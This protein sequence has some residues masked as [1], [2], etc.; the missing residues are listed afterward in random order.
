LRRTRPFL[1]EADSD[2]ALRLAAISA[3]TQLTNPRPRQEGRS[4][5]K[6]G[7]P[8]HLW[9]SNR[10]STRSPVRETRWNV[11]VALRNLANPQAVPALKRVLETN[12]SKVRDMILEALE[13]SGR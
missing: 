11:A 8:T 4:Y 12:H 2:R 5:K 6:I 7:P 3:L 13:N 1:T 9:R 10:L